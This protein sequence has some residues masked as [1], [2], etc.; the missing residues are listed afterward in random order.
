MAPTAFKRNTQQIGGW[1]RIWAFVKSTVKLAVATLPA[2]ALSGTP[3]A[4]A[5]GDAPGGYTYDT[6][7]VELTVAGQKFRIPRNYTVVPSAEA[8][9]H[10]IA[11]QLVLPGLDGISQHNYACFI[12]QDS[13]NKIVN[14]VL[15]DRQGPP[16]SAQVQGLFNNPDA[17]TVPGPFG[18]VQYVES[19]TP[20]GRDL[21]AKRLGEG[22]YWISCSKQ[23]DEINNC[24]Y[25]QRYGSGLQLRYW[26]RRTQLE[27]WLDI[28]QRIL[29]LWASFRME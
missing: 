27:Y 14:I 3:I 8:N 2:I 16:V 1:N 15:S 10:A 13:C 24:H 21:Y 18:L 26:F 5:Q 7:P 25:D 4:H 12:R 20:R 22:F 6:S 9:K 11:L 29:S 19:K 23:F 28:H 17:A